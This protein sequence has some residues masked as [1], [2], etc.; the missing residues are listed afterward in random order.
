M[1]GVAG[2]G[3]HPDAW[4]N[5]RS[6]VDEH[7]IPPA[8]DPFTSGPRDDHDERPCACDGG[9]VT[10]GY[11]AESADDLNGEVEV[12]ERIPCKKCRGSA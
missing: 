4:P 11:M 6:P 2:D 1:N 7:T 12:F 10:I 8:G 5:R 9:W 3:R